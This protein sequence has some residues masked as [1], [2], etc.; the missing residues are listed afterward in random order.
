M[1]SGH[2]CLI[3]DLG[4]VKGGKGLR[5]HEVVVDFSWRGLFK[6]VMSVGAAALR[7]RA[8]VRIETAE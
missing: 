2:Y 1:S 3:R 7:R 6:F 5:H 8:P 4:L